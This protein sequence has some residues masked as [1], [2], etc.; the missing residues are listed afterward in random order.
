MSSSNQVSSE[1]RGAEP[2]RS[3]MPQAQPVLDEWGQETDRRTRHGPGGAVEYCSDRIGLPHGP[4]TGHE[5]S[6]VVHQQSRRDGRVL[7]DGT[8]YALGD[9]ER[10]VLCIARGVSGGRVAG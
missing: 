1:P 7:S 5:R 4:K 2:R 6:A 8:V 10:I 9:R 3:R